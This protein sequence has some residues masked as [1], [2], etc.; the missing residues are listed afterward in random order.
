MKYARF[1]YNVPISYSSVNLINELYLYKSGDECTSVTGGWIFT[2]GW[3]NTS[4]EQ[5]SISRQSEYIQFTLYGSFM[6]GRKGGIG[7][8]NYVDLRDFTHISIEYEQ[9]GSYR[10]SNNGLFLIYT[11]S[12]GSSSTEITL[13]RATVS[14]KI[15][16]LTLPT[17]AT[18]DV[19]IRL[20]EMENVT[21]VVKIYNVWLHY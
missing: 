14:R 9:S 1:I 8:N 3:G 19:R 18:P 10:Y 6:T 16:T 2:A 12:D 5:T 21:S 7:T 13:E 4:E 20:V 17:L 11:P 15:K